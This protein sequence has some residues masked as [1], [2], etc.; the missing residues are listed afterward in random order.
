MVIQFQAYNFRDFDN[1]FYQYR[2]GLFDENNWQVY[3]RM[4]KRLLKDRYVIKML[5]KQRT[6][7]SKEFQEVIESIQNEK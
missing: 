2:L 4:I 1:S 3:R 5:E 7:F 6:N